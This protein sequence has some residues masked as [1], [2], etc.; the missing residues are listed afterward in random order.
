MQLHGTHRKP[1]RI[2]NETIYYGKGK[3]ISEISEEEMKN[4]LL[5]RE[6]ESKTAYDNNLNPFLI[7]SS[8]NHVDNYSKNM[9]NGKKKT[10]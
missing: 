4:E 6:T 8:S 2:Y 7:H 5:E 3:P 10:M 9:L 1:D